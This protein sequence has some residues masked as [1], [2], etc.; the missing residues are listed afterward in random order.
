MYKNYCDIFVLVQRCCFVDN[1][2]GSAT[3]GA[4]IQ[5]TIV[6]K[7]SSK[8]EEEIRII[9]GYFIIAHISMDSAKI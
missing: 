5:M 3:A 8:D 6:E 7:I 9:N 2:Y 4:Y 1:L